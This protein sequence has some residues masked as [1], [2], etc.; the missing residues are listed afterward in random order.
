M[1]TKDN[2][3]EEYVFSSPWNDNDIVL[4]VEDQELHV[5]KWILKSHSPVFKAMFEGHFQ[6]ACQDKVTLKEKEYK[7]MVQFLKILYPSTL[8]A[9]ARKPLDDECRL[10]IMELADEYQCDNLIKQY[11]NKAKITPGIALQMLPYV[12]KYH[13]T[14][15]PKMYDVIKWGASTAKLE[16]LV[17]NMVSKET[18]NMMLLNKC[19]FLESNVVSMQNTIVSLIN[20]FL[21]QKKLTSEAKENSSSGSTGG[22]FGRQFGKHRDTWAQTLADSRC[23]QS[24]NVGEINNAKTCVHCREKYKGK[25]LDPI[26]SCENTHV[27]FDMLRSRDN[28]ATAVREQK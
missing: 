3:K 6:E 28:V 27:F 2:E 1:A 4:V 16:E 24:V 21:R 5:H 15:L 11:I 20:D 10:S 19:H 8:F 7:S 25:F 13:Q 12:V 18:S 26:P 23:P 9:E 22:Y 14:A 17:G